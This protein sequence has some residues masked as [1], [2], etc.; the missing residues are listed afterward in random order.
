MSFSQKIKSIFHTSVKQRPFY[1]T[2]ISSS[3]LLNGHSSL[4]AACDHYAH[5]VIV[6]RCIQLISRGV[7]SIPWLLYKGKNEVE[8]H[9]LLSL[10][11]IPNI[12]QADATFREEL[13]SHLLMFGNVYILK[14]H[15][16]L[17]YPLELN[18]LHPEHMKIVK[19]DVFMPKAYEYSANGK[20]YSFP[21]DLLTGKSDVLHI[22]FFNPLDPLYG[23]APLMA[24]TSAINQHNAVGEHNLSLLKNGGRPSGAFIIKP[25]LHG[26]GLTDE[27]R[28]SLASDIKSIYEGASNAGRVLFLE[29]DF[30]WKEMGTTLKDLDFLSGKNLSAREIAQA[31]GVPPMLVGVPG[32]A[33][34]SNY[35][36]ARYHLWEDTILPLMDLIVGEFNRWI[37]K[38]FDEDL[39]IS[40]DADAI[41]ALALKREASWEKIAHVD[42]LTTDEKRQ[43]VGYGKLKKA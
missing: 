2:S 16:P 42:F 23:M 41:P 5:N 26:I 24:A 39:T 40:Y 1:A 43:A 8:N 32:D 11:C 27:Q 30:E 3:A 31:F 19:S 17:D 38:D 29:G 36:E 37:S 12:K 20:K 35:R 22:K 34:F 21:I 13:I 14:T 10:L 9:P 28:S 7:G 6:Y 15:Q 33:T 4:T 18:L 25:D